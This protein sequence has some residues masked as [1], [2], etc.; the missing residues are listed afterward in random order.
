MP[1]NPALSDADLSAIVGW[2]LGNKS[3]RGMGM[4]TLNGLAV[5]AL[6][7]MALVSACG[8]TRRS[9]SRAT[10]TATTAT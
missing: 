3:T 1:P 5:G 8:T 10:G 9:G 6:L 4:K 2:V 7:S